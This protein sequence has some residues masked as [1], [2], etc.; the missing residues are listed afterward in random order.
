MVARR[1]VPIN[2]EKADNCLVQPDRVKIDQGFAR[3][4][5]IRDGAGESF[6]FRRDDEV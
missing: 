6:L 1:I 3:G 4:K 5:G 2:F